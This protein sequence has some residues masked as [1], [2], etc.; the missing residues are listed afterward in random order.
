MKPFSSIIHMRFTL[1]LGEEF[2]KKFSE[3]QQHCSGLLGTQ[4]SNEFQHDPNMPASST[5]DT[6][7]HTKCSFCI[8]HEKMVN[9][10]FTRKENRQYIPFSIKIFNKYC[11]NNFLLV[12]LFFFVTGIC[13][14]QSRLGHRNGGRNAGSQGVGSTRG[15]AQ[16]Q[17][18]P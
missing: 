6:A 5:K 7:D 1:S 17:R 2:K 11:P 18:S 16:S 9:P 15:L 4:N 10:S 14:S 12:A 8:N 13:R 3:F